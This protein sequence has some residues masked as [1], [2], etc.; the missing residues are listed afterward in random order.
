[1]RALREEPEAGIAELDRVTEQAL[2]LEGADAPEAREW[3]AEVDVQVLSQGA[4]VLAH[5]DRLEAAIDRMGRA[6]AAATD[7]LYAAT[8]TGERARFLLLADR[9]A[10][11]DPLLEAVLPVLRAPETTG[12][13]LRLAGQ[14]AQAVHDAGEPER[15]ERI[16]AAYGP[17]AAPAG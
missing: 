10:E 3:L 8:L 5:R 4:A 9:L 6:E 16:W 7:P 15:A 1:M 17:D 13:R 11:A 2:A 14:W 12:A